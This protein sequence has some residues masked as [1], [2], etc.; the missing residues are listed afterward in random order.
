VLQGTLLG[1]L[2]APAQKL[3]ALLNTPGTQLARVF[4]SYAEKSG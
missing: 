4:K 1:V 2:L 3:V